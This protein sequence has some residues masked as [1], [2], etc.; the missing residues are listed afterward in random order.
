LRPDYP[1]GFHNLA[2]TLAAQGEFAQA[3]A[4]NAEALRLQPEHPGAR[5]CRALWWLQQG[6]FERGWP[7]YEWRWKVRGVAARPFRQP[8]WAGL[9]LAGRTILLYAEQ[10]LGDTLQF[11]RY[12]P[13]VKERGGTV[14]V[15]CQAPLAHLLAGCPGIDRLVPRG[16]PLPDFDVQAPLLSLPRILRT[17]L[18][19]VPANVPYIFPDAG[20]V[21]RWRGELGADPSV[22]VGI[23]WQGRTTFPGDR[24]RSLPLSH[25][26]PL[27]RVE[28]VRLISLQ[29]GPAREQIK[30]VARRF[31]VVDLGGRLDEAT[32]AF[33]DTAAVMKGLDLVVTSDTSVA[34]LA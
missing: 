23:A 29:K 13:L 20:L 32:G 10:A 28:G 26:D 18:A 30:D 15:E 27:A 14:V 5:N 25:F 33:M 9:P 19:A 2:V 16:S 12:A 24:L 6:D 8:A 21:T 4:N 7:E 17:A 34:H 1:D 11:I 31:A 3:L 22:K